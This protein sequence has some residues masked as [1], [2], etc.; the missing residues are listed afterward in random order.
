MVLCNTGRYICRVLIGF[1]QNILF[2]LIKKN[3]NVCFIKSGIGCGIYTTNTA[4]ACEF[5]LNDSKSEIIVVENQQQ[6]DKILK[7]K[8]KCSIKKIIQYTGKI[9]NRHNDLVMSVILIFL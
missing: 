5:I 1:I 3:F 4:E 6:L 2:V 9:E 7:S 8:D